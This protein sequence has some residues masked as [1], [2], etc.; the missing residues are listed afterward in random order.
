MLLF[1][2]Y[3][4][5]HIFS[6]RQKTVLKEWIQNAAINLFATKRIHQVLQKQLSI[7]IKNSNVFINP[8]TFPQPEQAKEYPSLQNGNFIL[9]MFAALDVYR[10]AQDK[11]VKILSAGK[12]KE[13][14]WLLYLYGEGKDKDYLRELI[15]GLGLQHKIVLKGYTSSVALA[16]EE[17]HLVLQVS[18]I[19][20]MPLSV[21]EAMAIGRPLVVSRIGDMPFWVEEGDNG[22][23]CETDKES[24]EICLE[25]AWQH[26]E[27]WGKM[28]KRSFEIFKKKFPSNPEAKFLEQLNELPFPKK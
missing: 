15:N 6:Q 21:I 13:R 4:E 17:A 26:R 22:W 12:W 19:D 14:V 11:L 25:N 9:A 2:N 18:N 16:M 20:A 7:E 10:K 5:N 23:V 3:E 1:H 8:I 24:I 27:L 28:G